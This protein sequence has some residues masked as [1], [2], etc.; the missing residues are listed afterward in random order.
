MSEKH[1]ILGGKVHIYKRPGSPV[2]QSSTYL[3]GKNRRVSTKEESLSKAKEVAEDWYLELRGKS[4]R[5][6]IKNEKTFK[7]ASERFTIE[8]EVMTDGERNAKYVQDHQSRLRNHLIPYF[9]KMGLSEITA[10][11][12]QEYRLHRMKGEDGFKPPARSTL[13]HEVVTLRQVLKTAQR[14]GWIEGLPDISMP[15]RASSK[16]V[17][18]AWFSPDEYKTLYEAS[19]ENAKAANGKSWQWAAEQLHDK[20]LFMA[21]TGIRPDEANW[22]EYRDIQII[23]DEATKETILLIEVRGKR[24]VGY[25]KSMPG[26]VLPFKRMQE[27][28]N[29]DPTDKLF[30]V[31]H[32]K[33]FNGILERTNLKFDRQGNRRTLYSLRHSYISF[34]L[35][36]GADIYQI[37]KNCRTSVEM[38]EKHYAAHLANQIDASAVNV[39]RSHPTKVI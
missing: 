11:V 36:E 38:I 30:P 39:R 32:K 33:Q 9:G 13:L 4:S 22:L 7:E 18:R 35:L 10:G 34:R 29:P 16:V 24:G 15:Y 37:A 27:R 20:I 31:D 25:C 2:W 5:G 6:E 1:T 17:H 3:A 28:N 21:N 12:V 14:H 23:D 8:Y 19:R 26:A